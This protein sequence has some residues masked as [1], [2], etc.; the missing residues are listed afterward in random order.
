[1]YSSLVSDAEINT[2]TKMNLG[3]EGLI[4]SYTFSS[5]FIV[6]G[7]QGRNSGQEPAG[8]I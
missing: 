2:I 1:M 7:N 8:R 6:D 5:Q 4:S 3:R